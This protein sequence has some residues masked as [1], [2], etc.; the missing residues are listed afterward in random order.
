ML[1]KYPEHFV[2]LSKITINP[3]GVMINENI[4]EAYKIL[5]RSTNMSCEM[6]RSVFATLPVGTLRTYNAYQQ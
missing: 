4:C 2:A 6:A 3:R 5:G 1:L